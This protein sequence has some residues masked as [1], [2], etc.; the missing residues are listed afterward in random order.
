FDDGN[1]NSIDVSQN[2]IIDDITDPVLPVLS[3]VT[4]EC[5]AT[6][7][8]PTTTDACAGTITGT[9]TDPLTYTT[10]GTHAI[11]WTFD[12]GNG[13]SIDVIQNVVLDDITDP[14]TPV[15]ADV[16]GECS[17]TAVIPTTTDACAGTITGTTTDSLTYTTEGTHAITWTF[18]D[19]NGNSIDVIQNVVLDDTIDPDTPVLANLTGEC[20]V[21]AVAP[22]TTDACVGTITGTTTDSLTYITQGIYTITWTFD[23][24][25]GN[26]IDVTQNVAIVDVTAPLTPI[27][28]DLKDENSV[29]AVAPTTT[30]ACAGTITGTTSDTLTYNTVGTHVITWTFDDG[31]GNSIDVSQNVIIE[32]DI[33]DPVIPTLT[34]VTGECS[35]TA[36]APTTTDDFAGTITG[37]TSDSLTYTSQGTYMITWTFDDGNGNSIEVIQNVVV[38]DIT[39]PSATSPDEVVTC[40]GTVSS[41]GL[42]DVYDNCTIPVISYELSGA[43]SGSGTGDASAALF[44]PGVTT[45]TYVLDDG[46]GN[47]SQ[48]TFTVNN[49]ALTEINLS[50]DGGTITVETPGSYQ[51]INCEDNSMIDGQT[52][53]TFAPGVNGEYAVIVSQG[54]CPDTSGCY[55]LD[56]TGMGIERWDAFKVY[57][58]PAHD[59]VSIHMDKEH[60]NVTLRVVDMTGKILLIEEMDR[61]TRTDLDISR[62]KAGMYLIHI[63]SDKANSVKKFVKE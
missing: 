34:D 46:N 4:G 30:D 5:S 22:T 35:A 42:T 60:T 26:S 32:D 18:D 63:L 9:T 2:V 16:T 11:T 31:N 48:Y 3:D 55:T 39:P 29:T 17:A 19:G 43:T 10:E 56:Y 40:K 54:L 61:M 62:Y 27:L 45:V 44:M 37:T 12:D 13:N 50:V 51:W 15:L 14:D 47:S 57:P 25:N 21:T 41:I 24:G 49:Q 6:A 1:G 58:N 59:F 53:S 23:D 7:I 38:D 36:V 33:T 20:S 28:P 8:T 52:G